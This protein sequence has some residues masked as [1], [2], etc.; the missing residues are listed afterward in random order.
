MNKTKEQKDPNKNDPNNND[1]E[2]IEKI[3]L[4]INGF[5]DFFLYTDKTLSQ[6]IRTNKKKYQNNIIDTLI[7]ESIGEFVSEYNIFVKTKNKEYQHH[8]SETML[9]SK[10][11]DKLKQEPKFK[12]AI[13]KTIYNK[14]SEKTLIFFTQNDHIRIFTQTI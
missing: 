4:H 11:K 12:E 3:T 8:D 9:C 10:L 5:K 14:F 1:I 6:I 13:E 7:L 2:C